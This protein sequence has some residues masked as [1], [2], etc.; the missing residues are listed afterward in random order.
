MKIVNL[1][2]ICHV[3]FRNHNKYI[4]ETI[5]GVKYLYLSVS[6]ARGF[7]LRNELNTDEPALLLLLTPSD[8]Q[9]QYISAKECHPTVYINIDSI[10]SIWVYEEQGV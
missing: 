6:S 2:M 1:G 10:K 9:H 7:N 8:I 5:N 3:H 4:I